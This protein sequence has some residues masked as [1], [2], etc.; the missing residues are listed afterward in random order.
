VGGAPVFVISLPL[1]LKLKQTMN[2]LKLIIVSAMFAAA[3]G[4]P[5]DTKKTEQVNDNSDQR[6]DGFKDRFIENL[7]KIY[8]SWASSQGYHRYDS[9][10]VVPSEESR[11]K[12]NAFVQANLDSLKAYDLAKLSSNNKTDYYLIENQL[13]ELLWNN[14]SYKSYEWNPSDYNVVSGIAELLN[15]T[16]DKLDERLMGIYGRLKNAPAYYESAEKYIKNPTKV[17]TQLGMEQNLNSVSVLE[18]DLVDSVKKSGLSEPVKKEFQTRINSAVKS[19]KAY[20]EWL[21][22]MKNDT[23]RSFHLGKELFEPK[24]QFDIQS[25]FTAEE[26]YNRAVQRK[27]E[28]HKEMYKLSIQLADKYKCKVDAKDTL[29]TIRTVIDAIS[30]KHVNRD[31]FQADIE[32]RIPQLVEYIKQKNLIYI[33]PAK[34]LVVRKEPAY[35]AGVAGASINAPGPYDKNGNT[36]YNVGSLSSWPAEKAESYLREYNYYVLQILSIHEAIP[37]HYTQLVY[38]NQSPSLIKSLFGNGAMV[39]GW[40]VYT[41]RMMME[42]GYGNNEPEMWLMYYKWHLRAVC[43]TILDYSVHVLGMEKDDALKLLMD[44]AFQQKAEAEG[45]WRRVSLTQVQLCSYFTGF[46]EIY[47]LR[48]ELKQKMGDKFNLKA[49]HEKFLSYGSTPVKYIRELM[50]EDLNSEKTQSK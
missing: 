3:C 12:E 28:L 27:K 30:L 4:Q 39:E 33:D 47:D 9:I 42:S 50:L 10:L 45:K 20:A 23:P 36:Y 48:E 32:K 21:K 43:N 7:W 1:T 5:V 22:T 8:P 16:Y 40:A 34:P 41:E 15:G 6:F 24:F 49:F 17:H 37:G 35:M 18:K 14:Q 25:R 11:A 29:K 44:E 13:K 2:K 46:T 31:S 26:I 38:S 19:V